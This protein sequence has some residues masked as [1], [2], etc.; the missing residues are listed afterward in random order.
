MI[1]SWLF[2]CRICAEAAKMK[3]SDR[4]SKRRF[5]Y[6]VIAFTNKTAMTKLRRVPIR[7]NYSFVFVIGNRIVQKLFWCNAEAEDQQHQRRQ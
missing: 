7:C 2:V 6:L 4:I 1:G 3:A 5:C